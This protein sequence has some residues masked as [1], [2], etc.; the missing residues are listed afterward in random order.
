MQIRYRLFI[1]HRRFRLLDP[2]EFLFVGIVAIGM[3]VR[4]LPTGDCRDDVVGG[5]WRDL[6]DLVGF[7]IELVFARG[8]RRC[9]RLWRLSFAC[10]LDNRWC[11]EF[12]KE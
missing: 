6:Q 5:V 1:K 8:R 2:D 10:Y 7:L 11:V 12:A 4:C 9:D 3:D